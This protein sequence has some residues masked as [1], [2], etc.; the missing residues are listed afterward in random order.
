VT[1]GRQKGIAS[2]SARPE[3]ERGLQD[4]IVACARWHK[5][6]VFHPWLSAHSA[7]GWPTEA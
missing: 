6:L 5:W 3:T 4:A 1:P 7:A 2:H